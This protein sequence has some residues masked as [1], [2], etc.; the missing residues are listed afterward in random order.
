MIYAANDNVYEVLDLFDHVLERYLD[1]TD[2]VLLT[3]RDEDGTNLANV[4]WP[5][6]MAYIAGTQGGFRAVLSDVMTVPINTVGSA[7]IVV[8]DDLQIQ[9]EVE[10]VSRDPRYCQLSDLYQQFGRKNVR[11]WADVDNDAD[12]G[13]MQ[14]RIDQG[15]TY[16][17]AEVDDTLRRGRYTLPFSPVPRQ[18]RM[19]AAQLAGVYL[20]V[21]RGVEDDETSTGEHAYRHMERMARTR[22]RRLLSGQTVLDATVATELKEYPHVIDAP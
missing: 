1:G 18:I 14:S 5:A 7:L 16:A 8:T 13:H 4:S 10:Y 15:I 21:S 19:I 3:L 6:T 11:A 2:A 20:Y 17:T 9:L 12:E 22:L